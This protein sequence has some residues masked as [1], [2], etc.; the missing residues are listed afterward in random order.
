MPHDRA[1]TQNATL[2]RRRRGRKAPVLAPPKAS[3][4]ERFDSK[5]VSAATG[6]WLWVGATYEQG[7]G[8]FNAGEGRI[9]RAHRFSFER[10]VGP[11]P[12]GMTIDHICEV[13]NCVNP[14]HLEIVTAAE[15]RRRYRERQR[16]HAAA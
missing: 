6:C 8:M 3:T 2:E 5:V 7:Y 10:R 12:Q 11:I 4:E 9:V 14:N 15:N 13:K 16:Q 1:F